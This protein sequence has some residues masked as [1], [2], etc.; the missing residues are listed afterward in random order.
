MMG[1][2][3]RRRDLIAR[4]RAA[5]GHSRELTRVVGIRSLERSLDL[6]MA[7]EERLAKSF[8]KLTELRTPD[9]ERAGTGSRRHAPSA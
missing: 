6:L 4:A 3:L 8:G 2:N 7:S 5:I 9:D 1:H